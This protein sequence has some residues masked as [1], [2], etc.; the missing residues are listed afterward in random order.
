MA[1]L[2]SDLNRHLAGDFTTIAYVDK[3]PKTQSTWDWLVD[4][5]QKA[6]AGK[7]DGNA[8]FFPSGGAQTTTPR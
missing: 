1:S 4:G 7:M 6:D 5:G 3:G 8:I 2:K